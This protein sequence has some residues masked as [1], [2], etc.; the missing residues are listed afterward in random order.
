MPNEVL[1]ISSVSAATMSATGNNLSDSRRRDEIERQTSSYRLVIEQGPRQGT[2]I[3]KT[4]DR[5]TGETIKQYPREEVLR[6]LNSPAYA[7]GTVADT[8]A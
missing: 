1:P 5:S 4:V 3:Y 8:Q 7:A 2:F 6:L